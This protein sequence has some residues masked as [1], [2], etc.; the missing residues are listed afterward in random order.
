MSV[1]RCVIV[2][3]VATAFGSSPWAWADSPPSANQ[4][5][6][7]IQ[8]CLETIDQR[9]HR[10]T[11]RPAEPRR[12]VD[13]RLLAR[14]PTGSD[15]VPPTG[16][17]A[18][19]GAAMDVHG[20]LR[21][22]LAYRAVESGEWTKARHQLLMTESGRLTDALAYRATQRLYYDPVYAAT[23]N[24]SSSAQHSQQFEAELRDTYLDYS[25]GDWDIRLGKQ[26]IVWGESV[27]L[28]FADVVN[29]K[30]LREYILPDFDL[31]RIP[32]WAIDVERS[33][34]PTHLEMVWLP[35]REF[36]RLG[37][38]GSE[39]EPP[40]P[41][42]PGV[43]STYT[44][45][46]K[47][48][49]S[50]SNSE[51]GLRGSLLE[52]GWDLGAFYLYTWDKFPVLYRSIRSTT[53]DFSPEYERAHLMG[54]TLSKEIRDVILKGEL[55]YNP[56]NHLVTFNSEDPDGIVQRG[57]IDYVL[58]A[59][60]TFFHSLDTN[61][62]LMQRLIMDH[63]DLLQEETVRTHLSVRLSTQ[64]LDHKL[65]PEFLLLSGLGEQD[66]L[67]RPRLTIHVTDNLRFRLGADLFQ[68]H[69]D[70]LFGRFRGHSRLY[71]ELSLSF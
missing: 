48:P 44:D 7:L 31:I 58:G 6:R 54:T 65:E 15:V 38:S 62:Q 23:D 5:E 60:Y 56:K 30:D 46:S 21:Q 55:V 2:L 24:F 4:R 27:G 64:L 71:T 69:L 53:F 34:D 29:A 68:G 47:P 36:N 8:L 70:G 52:S 41:L 37:V 43:T 57:T 10:V 17:S 39:F 13:E 50:V 66:V 22:E 45:P 33:Q 3:W 14:L 26:Q 12:V 11:A 28:F 16:G 19:A 25:Q 35:I 42:P 18:Q 67:Y 49:A 9:Q 40:L 63:P 32:Q 20:E 61:L 59:D 1:S 51:I